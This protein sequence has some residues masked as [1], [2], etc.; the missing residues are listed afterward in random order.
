MEGDEGDEGVD[1]VLSPSC[2]AFNG[3]LDAASVSDA[4]RLFVSL[5]SAC[6]ICWQCEWMLTPIGSAQL[7]IVERR[8]RAAVMGEGGERR[9]CSS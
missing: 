4:R 8:C 1:G 9:C 7:A 5:S 2:S 3:K 6:C